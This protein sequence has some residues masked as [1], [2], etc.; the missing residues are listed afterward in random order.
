MDDLPHLA[1]P[2]RVDGSSYAS[3]Q[4][5]TDDEVA[6]TVAV[7]L[8]FRRGWRAEQP[9]FGITDPTFELTP[10]NTAEIERQVGLYEPR[11]ELEITLSD[12][13]RGA[14][15]VRIAATIAEEEEF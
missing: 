4:Q 12:D 10:I 6:A 13:G 11:A 9:D 1:W 15:R 7:L 3:I 8:S 2:V 5:D 14:Q